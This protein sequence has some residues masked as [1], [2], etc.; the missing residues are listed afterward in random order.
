M[1]ANMKH[2]KWVSA[3]MA[4]V[5]VLLVSQPIL[6]QKQFLKRLKEM[7]PDLDKKFANCHIC[8]TYSQEKKETAEKENLNLFG[9]DLQAADKNKMYT[10]KKDGDEH[11][12]TEEEIAAIDAALKE[13]LKKDSNGNGK[14]NEEDIKASVNPGEKK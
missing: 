5:M 12:F 4:L 13:V 2:K 3:L 1:G 9:K 7:F 14:S 8:H 10:S 6:A 11:K